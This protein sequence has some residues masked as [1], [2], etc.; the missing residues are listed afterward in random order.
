MSKVALTEATIPVVYKALINKDN[1]LESLV[2]G[3]GSFTDHRSLPY[4]VGQ[5]TYAPEGSLGI[6]VDETLADAQGNAQ[7]NKSKCRKVRG[8]LVVHEAAPLGAALPQEGKSSFE[9]YTRY[10]AILLGK[11]VWRETPP[12]KLELPDFQHSFVGFD[13]KPKSIRG[14][15]F[16]GHHDLYIYDSSGKELVMLHVEDKVIRVWKGKHSHV[17]ISPSNY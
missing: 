14:T 17:V 6:F 1:K 15:F 9:S 5:I 7:G 8:T 16:G 12:P 4:H 10:P 13:G 3:S 11:E 2:A